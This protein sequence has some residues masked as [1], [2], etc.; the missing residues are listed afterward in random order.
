MPRRAALLAMVSATTALEFATNAALSRR[1]TMRGLATAAAGT[2]ATTVAPRVA[3]AE[4][5]PTPDELRKLTLGYV[6]CADIPQTGRGDAAAV[7]WIVRGGRVAAATRRFDG[8]G[9][10]PT[11]LHAISTWHPAA[12]LR[13]VGGI[14]TR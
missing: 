7:T 11:A 4:S 3:A 13:P 2:L 12:V 10:A 8:R 14:S 5:V 6:R 9:A 1:H